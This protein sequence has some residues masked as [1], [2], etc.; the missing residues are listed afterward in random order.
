[1]APSTTFTREGSYAKFSEA[2]K[3]RRGPLGYLARAYDK[4]LQ[5]SKTF[6][7]RLCLVLG[8]LLLLLPA[9]LTPLFVC[10][11][12][13]GTIDWSWATVMVFV[14]IYDFMAC[15]GTLTWL[16][17]FLLHLF[18]VLRLDGH[19]DWSWICVFI[20][21]Y[22][23]VFDWDG[24]SDLCFA[25]QLIFLGLQL[26]HTVTWSWLVVFIPTWVPSAIGGLFF[27]VFVFVACFSDTS[28][29]LGALGLILLACLGF[30]LL[31]AP[32]VLLLVR[33]GSAT[34]SAVYIILPWL[35]LMGL[36]ALA[37]IA[38]VLFLDLDDSTSGPVTTPYEEV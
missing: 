8:G 31:V 4:L 11:K 2:A 20:P 7:V 12:V 36:V 37:G 35:I 34:F 17:G 19:V 26:D 10:W 22:V 3:A 38:A 28:S 33:L 6:G 27:I 15:N 1:M 25:L 16:C 9:V 23:S 18:V 24:S 5:Q 29:R 30:G 14:W 32:Q 13:D 21:A